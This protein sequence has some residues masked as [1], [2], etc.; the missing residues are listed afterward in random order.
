MDLHNKFKPA[1]DH[2]RIFMSGK[3]SKV[4]IVFPNGE[5]VE[6]KF[7]YFSWPQTKFCFISVHDHNYYCSDQT[8]FDNKSEYSRVH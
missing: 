6:G 7:H 5:I 8:S 1:P 2:P 4:V 3:S